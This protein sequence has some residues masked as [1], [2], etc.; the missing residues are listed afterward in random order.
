MS[1]FTLS[2]APR[3]RSRRRAFSLL[4]VAAAAALF[5]VISIGVSLAVGSALANRAS[6]AIRH[7]LSGELDLALSEI[8]YQPF[9]ELLENTF[10]PPTPCPGD[11]FLGTE[12]TTC[13]DVAN[14]R[15]EVEW[16]VSFGSDAVE[17]ST[18]AVSS[19]TLVGSTSLPDGSTLTRTRRVSAPTPGFTGAAL[20]RVQAFGAYSTITGPL[21]LVDADTP[22]EVV[23][24]ADMRSYGAALFRVEADACTDLDPCRVALAPTNSWTTDGVAALAPI[25]AIGPDSLISLTSG[26]IQQIG[27]EVFLPATVDIELWAESDL[28]ARAP[29]TVEDSICLWASFNDGAADRLVPSCNATPATV[30]FDTYSFDAEN[31]SF[32][33][34]FPPG[35]DLTF[36]VDHPNGTCPDIGQRGARDGV[37]EAAAVCTSWTWGVPTTLDTALTSV[38]FTSPVR[39]AA[40]AN[41]LVATWSG[42]LA[43]PAVGYGSRPLWTNPRG[44]GSC[45][46][47]A[48]CTSIVDS[49]PEDDI[50][51]GELCLSAR[52]PTLLAPSTG[53]V[54]AVEVSSTLTSFDLEA[55]DPYDDPVQVQ[56]LDLPQS[57]T[58]L[59]DDL[60]VGIGDIIGSTPAGGGSFELVF[61]EDAPIDLVWFTVRLSNSV[62][63]GVRDVEVALYREPL[64]WSLTQ[65]SVEVGQSSSTTVS[66]STI[67]VDSANPSGEVLSLSADAGI[68]VPST[69]TV[70][71][72]GTASFTIAA[73]AITPGEYEVYISAPGGRE[74]TVA[75]SVVQ[76]AASATLLAPNVEQGAQETATVTVRDA[77]GELMA[78]AN[79]SFA[80]DTATRFAT[81][82]R[83][84]P[85][86]CVTG[87]FGTCTV[88]VLADLSAPAGSYTLTATIGD[89]V[90]DD[91][92]TVSSVPGSF[93]AEPL[94]LR[95]G[96][97]SDWTLTLLDGAGTALIGR[98][99]SV[100]VPPTGVTVSPA[101]QTTSI[102]GTVSFT[103][104]ASAGASVGVASLPFTVSS[105]T[106]TTK[107]EITATPASLTPPSPLT[108]L[109]GASLADE[110]VVLDGSGDP[111]SGISLT[112]TPPA[113]FTV[114]VAPSDDD[115]IAN[116]TIT[117]LSTAPKGEVSIPISVEGDPDVSATIEI[118]AVALP[119][120][121]TF[122]GQAVIAGQSQLSVSVLDDDADPVEGA[123]VEISGLPSSLRVSP[124]AITD[125]SGVANVLITDTGLTA[126]GAYRAR[127]T[128]S[129]LDA[130]RFWVF[131]LPVVNGST[132]WYPPAAVAPP[133]LQALT[134]DSISVSWSEPVDDGGAPVTSYNVYV[135][136]ALRST[137]SS[138]TTTIDELT[139]NSVVAVQITAC[140]LYGC[141]PT[142]QASTT[143]TL[144]AAPSN[145][146]LTA[147]GERGTVSVSWTLP[148]G[149]L[150]GLSLRT[151]PTAGGS[152]TT[153][154]LTTSSTSYTLRSL[155]D[156]TS[157]DVQVG[158]SN[159]SGTTW[160]PTATAT[161]IS[162]PSAP[163]NLAVS[164]ASST[165]TLT[166]NAPNDSGGSAISSYKVFRDDVL[167][168]TVSVLSYEDAPLTG[169]YTWRVQACNTAGCSASSS[170][171]SATL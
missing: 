135:N 67:G 133:T 120:S 56:I 45:T 24:T 141:S 81:G 137:T 109:R 21:Y 73:G 13:L 86:G 170:A 112:A 77:E 62:P 104:T 50:C 113:G 8:A 57:G 51:P 5:G 32:R 101:S 163:L 48:T 60:P 102:T 53:L 127:A 18:S 92:F 125:A 49:A 22:T 167:V 83:P 84:V 122:S 128:I 59:F 11:A 47:T 105:R 106:I 43:R 9:N 19:A 146:V 117:A 118:D 108:I 151:R 41:R 124:R 30:R 159:E 26:V 40:G 6:A 23:S 171:I 39:L 52:V 116:L 103:I 114:S 7:Q 142:S 20:L 4:E 31:P 90:V 150:T 79:V 110:I 87:A 99:V 126:P 162:R 78:G 29:A 140:N 63:D 89:T 97:S 66:V 54:Y 12:G 158:A 88:Q 61:E 27:I 70:D 58:L 143:T 75:V 14:R 34:P 2:R 38:A 148:S 161:S 154:T 10:T 65:P 129:F 115:G 76:R 74:S 111:V 160:S 144:P 42:D 68:T 169:T 132:G 95:Q 166:W 119:S 37:F 28:G 156:G 136:S 168:A 72:N 100:G 64:V 69:A 46:E 3:L 153:R 98:P 155:T 145:L 138:T 139:A 1:R 71:A 33:A 131:L 55:S 147:S 91:G 134:S 93:S 123:V 44:L 121:T 96:T 80:T 130:P 164:A 25:S 17:F 152:W 94:V 82:V 165:A 85:A 35:V 107:L 16:A 149:S 157:Y 15:F 36:T